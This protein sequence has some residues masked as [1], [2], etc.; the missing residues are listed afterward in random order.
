MRTVVQ[1]ALQEVL[2]AEM[3]E[4]VG[5]CQGRAAGRMARL[6]LR[7]RSPS[8]RRPLAGL[9]VPDVDHSGRQAGVADTA[10]SGWPVL[11]RAVRTLPAFGADA[12]SDVCPGRVD[13]E[14]PA[15]GLDSRVEV[16]IKEL[17][18]HAISASSISAIAKEL[19]ASLA[20]FADPRLSEAFP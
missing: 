1:A 8:S 10:G 13:S 4:A 16:I 5:A 12:G 20:E 9:A 3:T 15:L 2:E 19:D 17:C 11:D 6:S 18:G 14:V 7:L